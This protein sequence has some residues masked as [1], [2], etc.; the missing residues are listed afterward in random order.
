MSGPAS[1]RGFL[2]GLTTLPL[3]GGG[4]TLIG[5][6]T[7]AATPITPGLLATYSNWLYHERMYLM[8]ASGWGGRAPGSVPCVTPA[9]DFHHQDGQDL[10]TAMRQTQQ[11]AAVIL[12]AAGCLL[13]DAAAEKQW[14]SA[15]HPMA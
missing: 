7:H 5:Q 6:P 11:R 13:T 1:R 14:A 4:V 10:E 12:A 2:R 8:H 15:F 3:I 9:D